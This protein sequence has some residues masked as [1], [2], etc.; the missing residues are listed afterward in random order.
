[1]SCFAAVV[2]GDELTIYLR[3]VSCD[4]FPPFLCFDVW[5]TR[6]VVCQQWRHLF[7]IK[8]WFSLSI[9]YSGKSQV[10][11]IWVVM[12]RTDISWA[13]FYLLSPSVYFLAFFWLLSVV[14]SN[15]SGFFLTFFFSSFYFI[16]F[17]Q[18]I[19][20]ISNSFFFLFVFYSFYFLFLFFRFSFLRI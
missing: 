6:W 8:M 19:L 7:L 2:I 9:S 12:N 18:Y 16:L 1:M 14:F 13:N 15:F 3:L 11:N 10:W 20:F 17:S 4:I 5:R